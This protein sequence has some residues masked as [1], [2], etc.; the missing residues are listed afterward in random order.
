M[1][2][3]GGLEAGIDCLGVARTGGS[4][5][6]RDAVN[7]GPRGSVFAAQSI[8]LMSMTP[9]GILGGN[10]RPITRRRFL[11]RGTALSAGMAFAGSLSSTVPE[12]N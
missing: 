11:E 5:G 12:A 9:W 4:D 1:V 2:F 8:W 10:M 7:A 3:D 6:I